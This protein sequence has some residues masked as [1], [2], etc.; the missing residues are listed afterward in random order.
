[1]NW[2]FSKLVEVINELV[3]SVLAWCVSIFTDSLSITSARFY[4]MF[5][6]GNNNNFL[7]SFQNNVIFPLA[8]GIIMGNMVVQ[9]YRSMFSKQVDQDVDEPIP[10]VFR[11][12]AY[13]FLSLNWN[14]LVFGTEGLAPENGWNSPCLMNIY[15]NIWGLIDG[16]YFKVSELLTSKNIFTYVTD[17]R[18][19]SEE[20]FK[21]PSIK[22]EEVRSL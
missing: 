20:Y 1:M 3:F 11:S 5:V 8:V 4:Q 19:L 21:L 10:L 18:Y 6:D 15:S 2:L 9:L 16:K 7:A 14:L 22:G 12:I 13:L 17:S